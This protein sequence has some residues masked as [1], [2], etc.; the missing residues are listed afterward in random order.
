[1]RSNVFETPVFFVSINIS[2]VCYPQC[3]EKVAKTLQREA[4]SSDDVRLFEVVM[5]KALGR[6]DF[7]SSFFQ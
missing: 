5:S 2:A 7:P 3:Q 4:Y 6:Y 1:M